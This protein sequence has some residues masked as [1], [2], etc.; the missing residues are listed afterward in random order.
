VGNRGEA[1]RK[2]M[3]I[4]SR[5]RSDVLI[6]TPG[7]LDK[8]GHVQVKLFQGFAVHIYHVPN[9]VVVVTDVR[10]KILRKRQMLRPRKRGTP[11]IDRSLLLVGDI[12]FLLWEFRKLVHRP[13][14][15]RTKID[16]AA[17]TQ[18]A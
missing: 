3:G 4:R 18:I 16:V 2:S 5:L 12:H 9:L 8:R 13:M 14:R 11:T 1:D 7:I 17:K 6:C 10:L 15:A